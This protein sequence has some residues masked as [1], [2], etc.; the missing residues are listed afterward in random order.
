MNTQYMLLL[1]TFNLSNHPMSKVHFFQFTDVKIKDQGGCHLP[2]IPSYKWQDW[3]FYP[4]LFDSR[5]QIA[6]HYGVFSIVRDLKSSPNK[7]MITGLFFN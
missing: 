4:D 6:N 3:N 7:L 5:S 1:F 2:V